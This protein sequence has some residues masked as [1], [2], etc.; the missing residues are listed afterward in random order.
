MERR[1]FPRRVP[2]A[3]FFE[4]SLRAE[5]RQGNVESGTCMKTPDVITETHNPKNNFTFRV[6]AYRE[7]TPRE[8]RKAYFVW[9]RQGDKR[10]SFENKTVTLTSIIGYNG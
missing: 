6:R 5:A 10:R 4:Y 8:M 9:S 2:P 7:L 3:P 1:T